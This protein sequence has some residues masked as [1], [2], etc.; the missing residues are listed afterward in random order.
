M[1]IHVQPETEAAIRERVE[2]GRYENV[3]AVVRAALHVLHNAEVRALI[4]EGRASLER[5]EGVELTPEVWDEIE[6]EADEMIRRGE[7]PAWH[8]RP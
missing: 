2:S 6:R 7:Q 1:V 5:G 4:E 8:V 3:D